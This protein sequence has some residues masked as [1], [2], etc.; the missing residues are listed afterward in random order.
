MWTRRD[1]FG[2]AAVVLCAAMAS[3]AGCNRGQEQTAPADQGQ[4]PNADTSLADTGR[5]HFVIAFL[6]DSLTAG[7]GLVAQQSFPTLIENMFH[8]E[9]Y[10]DVEV[11]NGGMTGDTTA[12]GLR[13]VE[14]LLNP[15][16]RIL[17]IGLGGNDALRGLT[18][19]QTHDNL[20]AIIDGV[21]RSGVGVVLAGM[22]APTNYGQDYQDAFRATFG[23]LAQEHRN[24]TFVP[25][26]L[27]G[28]G[29][30]PELNQADGI[31]PN[32]DGARIIAE[33]LYPKLR[34]MVDSLGGGG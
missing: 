8:A 14:Q 10:G 16:V 25:F 21:N 27:E 29:G 22:E 31:H 20:A 15:N 12:G 34:T 30:H 11:L 6:G 33:H 7:Y 18:V 23:Q 4:V 17:V 2:L 9:G 24:V 5:K 1:A 3:A 19:K 32:A 13:R 26:L 28:V